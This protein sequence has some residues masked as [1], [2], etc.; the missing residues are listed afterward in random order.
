MGCG[1]GYAQDT[2]RDAPHQL[3]LVGTDAP[4]TEPRAGTPQQA[5]SGM[6][7][8]GWNGLR[9][10]MPLSHCAIFNI[11]IVIHVLKLLVLIVVKWI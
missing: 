9:A 10:P 3:P 5:I 11:P 4:A 7:N 6:S 1:D 8:T 2:T